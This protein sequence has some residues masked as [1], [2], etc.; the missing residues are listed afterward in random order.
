M[1][2]FRMLLFEAYGVMVGYVNVMVYINGM[3][4]V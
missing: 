1:G 3:F 4:L 2:F